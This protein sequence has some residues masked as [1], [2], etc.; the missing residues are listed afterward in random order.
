[1]YAGAGG[2]EE[3]PAEPAIQEQV[4]SVEPRASDR[5]SCLQMNLI[6]CVVATDAAA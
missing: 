1:M 4:A 5:L 3:D 2:R 6:E